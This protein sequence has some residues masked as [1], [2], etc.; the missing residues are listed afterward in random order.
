[1]TRQESDEI[2]IHYTGHHLICRRKYHDGP[3]AKLCDFEGS[4]ADLDTAT[5]VIHAIPCECER[6]RVLCLQL[7]LA[8]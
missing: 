6:C 2:V 4:L 8:T 5:A 1:M 3:W 7:T